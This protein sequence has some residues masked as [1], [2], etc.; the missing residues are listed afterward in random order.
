MR[1][2][3]FILC[4]GG[5]ESTRLL[6]IAR[7]QCSAWQR[8]DGVL[9]HYYTCHYDLVFGNLR[10]QGE[11]PHFDFQKTID[12]IYARRKLQFS[13]EYQS[14]NGLLNSVFRLHFPPYGDPSHGSGVLSLIYL[15]KSILVREHQDILNHGRGLSEDDQSKLLHLRN[16]LT[17][18]GSVFRFGGDWLFKM[19]LAQRKLPYTLIANR[20][21][22]YPL[23]FNSE[24]VPHALNRVE[25]IS[26]RDQFQM[27]RIAVHWRLTPEDIDSGIKSFECMQSLLAQTSNCRLEFDPELLREQMA[28]ALPI[29]G[30]HMG[31]TRMGATVSNSVV[32]Q[33]CQVHGVANLH[34][35]SS[36]VFPTSSYANPTLTIVCL[37]LRLADHLAARAT[38]PG[39]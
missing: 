23:E 26:Q 12:G 39:E 17:N 34:V 38:V 18:F 29:G 25:L 19:K 37:A 28:A 10:F 9:G 22:T 31:T 21:G 11:R 24:Q 13:A 20:N 27:P 30:H 15:L 2:G 35:A 36:S 8:F 7:Q 4:G 14:V 33:N 32:D 5:L 3:H 16:V 1:A 6:L